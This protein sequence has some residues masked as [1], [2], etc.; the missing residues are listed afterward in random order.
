MTLQNFLQNIKHR[1]AYSAK[2]SVN[3][4]TKVR[5][6]GLPMELNRLSGFAQVRGGTRFGAPLI[7]ISSS[8]YFFN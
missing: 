1:V 2:S 8:S 5:N 7:I 6:S 3:A 4:I